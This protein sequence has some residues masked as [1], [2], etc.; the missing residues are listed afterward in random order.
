[1]ASSDETV[2]FTLE[3]DNK[4]SIKSMKDLI[5]R[6]KELKKQLQKK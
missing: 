1:M 6:Q 4:G 5:D 2:V 3:I